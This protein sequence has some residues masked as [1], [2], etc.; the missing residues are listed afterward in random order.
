MTRTIIAGL[1]LLTFCGV[2]FFASA[3]LVHAEV[4]WMN[5][6]VDGSEN[7]SFISF[8]LDGSGNPHLAYCS[9][10]GNATELKYAY[11][12]RSGWRVRTLDGSGQILG[13]PALDLDPAG[14]P[15]IMYFVE[16]ASHG[17]TLEYVFQDR[18]FWRSEDVAAGNEVGPVSLAVDA[19]SMPHFS[20][21]SLDYGCLIYCC[22]NSTGKSTEK[23]TGWRSEVVDDSGSIGLFSA[24]KLDDSGIPHIAYLK[25]IGGPESSEFALCYA[26]KS[27]GAWISEKLASGKLGPYLSLDLDSS[28]MPHIGYVEYGTDVSGGD[29]SGTEVKHAYEDLEG[30]QFDLVAKEPQN[31]SVGR[32]FLAIYGLNTPH[33]TYP[34]AYPALH[35]AENSHLSAHSHAFEHA[36]KSGVPEDA[37]LI[38]HAFKGSSAWKTDVV[39]VEGSAGDL[40]W[41]APIG[42]KPPASIVIAFSGSRS[43][44]SIGTDSIDTGDIGMD[45]VFVQLR[46]A[47]GLEID[48]APAQLNYRRVNTGSKV[49][50]GYGD[51]RAENRVEMSGDVYP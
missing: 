17:L 46:Y 34:V 7:A 42:F 37:A 23:S 44:G 9:Q 31:S 49:A 35:P 20:C 25:R 38:K 26:C 19:N 24:L 33:M 4:S 22:K 3:G 5:E 40:N 50:A 12:G 16:D 27:G 15:H 48:S 11:K 18:H 14:Q 13:S 29:A 6:T 30:W 39:T 8:D 2:A 43:A 51:G 36:V 41:G 32:P 10:N 47:S 45:S 28:G 21:T 1:A